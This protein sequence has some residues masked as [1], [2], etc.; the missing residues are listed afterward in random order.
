MPFWAERE[1]SLWLSGEN[2]GSGGAFFRHM[3][4]LNIH[5]HDVTVEEAV[6]GVEFC[7]CWAGRLHT[8]MLG[9]E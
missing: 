7:L 9:K 5:A 8:K 3:P 2:E 6:T 4:F 1:E